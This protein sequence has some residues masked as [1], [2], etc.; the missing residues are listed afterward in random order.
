MNELKV[1]ENENFGAVRAM[2]RDGAPWFVAA[3]VCKAFGVVNSRNVV[4]RLDDDEKGVHD[5][6]TPGGTQSMTVVNEAG[7]YHMLFSMEPSNARGAS[8][9]GVN[10]RQEQLHAFKR[11]VTHD[12]I[13]AIRRTGMYA[14]EELLAD[15]DLAIAAFT[16]L[17]DE[18]ARRIA[19]EAEAKAN[20]PRVLFAQSVEASTQSI[21]VGELAKIMRQNGVE[22]GQNRLFE[23]LRADGFLCSVGTQRNM[24]TQRSMEMGLM[25]IKERS[26][27]NPDGTVRITLTPKVSGRGQVYFINRYRADKPA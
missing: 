6:D 19:L 17:R 10:E 9:D 18:R 11:W 16:Q 22:I 15:P 20:A 4:A 2:V 8:A 13:P 3:D 7:L 1:F 12:V 23:R 27:A 14:A 25:E 5:M 21:L 24:P 26:I